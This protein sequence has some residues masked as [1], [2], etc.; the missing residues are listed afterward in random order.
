MP[1]QVMLLNGIR[2]CGEVVFGCMPSLRASLHQLAA[3][4]DIRSNA[5]AA[6]TLA[7]SVVDAANRTRMLLKEMKS[8]GWVER[9]DEFEVAVSVLEGARRVRNALQHL[10][11]RI[12][13]HST[14]DSFP[15][16]WGSL[17]W[18]EID[19]AADG[20][21]T[22]GKSCLLSPGSVM[23]A[24]E[25]DVV[26]PVGQEFRSRLDQIHIEMFGQKVSL[27]E[28]ENAMQEVIEALERGL[29]KQVDADTPTHAADV[30]MILAF[31]AKPPSDES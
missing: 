10:D 28:L 19:I 31:E 1:K 18:A 17:T 16:A 7:W 9:S 15:P 24:T 2:F 27:S 25:T 6:M 20:T 22:G 12:D 29:R 4:G 5:P 30:L 3:T 11:E 8:S 14:G 21:A 13:R 23:G 26:N